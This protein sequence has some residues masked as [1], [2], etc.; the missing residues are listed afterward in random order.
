MSF[1]F[2]LP[3][4]LIS[5][6]RL[7]RSLPRTRAHGTEEIQNVVVVFEL[8]SGTLSLN[9]D[10]MTT[11]PPVR[12]LALLPLHTLGRI[13]EPHPVLLAVRFLFSFFLFF[14]KGPSILR[15]RIRD[16]WDSFFF[17]GQNSYIQKVSILRLK[18]EL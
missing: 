15:K 5:C 13:G 1:F 12:R 7:P 2:F 6:H 11:G 9:V 8:A 17:G 16:T 3:K 10:V 14:F 4:S 18:S